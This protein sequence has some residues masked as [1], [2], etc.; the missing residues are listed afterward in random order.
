MKKSSLILTVLAV[1]M[2]TGCTSK[3]QLAK[4]IEENPDIVFGAIKKD[5]KKFVEVVNEAVKSAQE[6]SRADEGKAEKARLEEEMK[7]PKQP[8]IEDGRVIFGNAK[9]PITIVDS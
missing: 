4:M 1:L 2:A 3:S 9:A 6:A 7:N 8:A 5:P